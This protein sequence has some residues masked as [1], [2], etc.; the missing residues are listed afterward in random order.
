MNI[1]QTISMSQIFLQRN[2]SE[3]ISELSP[4]VLNISEFEDPRGSLTPRDVIVS[5]SVGGACL[6][7]DRYLVLTGD[8]SNRKCNIEKRKVRQFRTR[9]MQ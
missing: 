9:K 1:T 4:E 3:P 5:V 6:Q 7:S 8:K 2:K